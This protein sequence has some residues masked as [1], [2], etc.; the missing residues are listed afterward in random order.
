GLAADAIEQAASQ[1]GISRP[2]LFANVVLCGTAAAIPNL[3][4]RLADELARISGHSHVPVTM[5]PDRPEWT[6]WR[7][8][9]AMARQM[10]DSDFK[11]VVREDSDGA[12]EIGAVL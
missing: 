10:P 1:H 12:V 3:Q 11:D 4:D 2:A 7:G 5:S 6:A 9:A 8:A